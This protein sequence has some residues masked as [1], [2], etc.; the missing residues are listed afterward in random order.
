MAAGEVDGTPV[1]VTGDLGRR[2]KVWD[3]RTGEARGEPLRGHTAWVTAVAVGKV[4]GI[5]IAVSGDN[6]GTI[7][8]WTLDYDH[9]ATARL[10]AQAGITAI[11]FADRIGWL[12]S[13]SDG[14]IFVWR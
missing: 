2:L 3:L 9:R 8:M 12:T 11:A 6:N 14:S 10:D 13:T 7:F 5:P 1:V 4:D